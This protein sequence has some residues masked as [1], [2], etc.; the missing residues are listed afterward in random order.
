MNIAVI[1]D[2]PAA[3][4]TIC[5]HIARWAGEH[6]PAAETECFSSGEAFEA[7]P[8]ARKYDIVFMDIIMDGKSG[9]E[10]ARRLRGENLDTLL[11]FITSS[12]DFM[13]EAFPCHAFD[14]IMKP[15]TGERIDQ[16]L[17]EAKRALDRGGE[18]IE[19]VADRR[20]LKLLLSDILYVYAHSNYCILHTRAGETKVRIS[21]TELS[22]R[23][24]RHPAFAV[25]GRGV[26]VNFDNTTHL[27]GLDCLMV[28][29][30]RVP[31]SRRRLRQTEQA[32]ID[33]QFARLLA[34][35]KTI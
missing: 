23:L 25:V 14:Y 24:L 8:N 7:R 31:V 19:V 11:I 12:P 32:F 5:A 4:E 13:A 22:Q 16:V 21:F 28:N 20:A 33:R 1:D 27:S 17:A 2:D 26:I 30:D 35:G 9:I 34:E 29:G 6:A 3:R 15:F 18:Y 10:T